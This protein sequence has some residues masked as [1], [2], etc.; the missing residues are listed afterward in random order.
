MAFD[1]G[2]TNSKNLQCPVN[3][4]PQEIR[5]GFYEVVIMTLAEA[6][7]V[8]DGKMNVFVRR[9]GPDGTWLSLLQVCRSIFNELSL[10]LNLRTTFQC[11]DIHQ[12]SKLL[13]Q[14]SGHLKYSLQLAAF[15]N[16]TPWLQEL[17]NYV[18]D[19]KHVRR[20]EIQ[21]SAPGSHSSKEAILNTECPGLAGISDQDFTTLC[22]REVL[23]VH[24]FIQLLGERGEV[25][26]H[27]TTRSVTLFRKEF[28]VL[29]HHTINA[30]QQQFDSKKTETLEGWLAFSGS[31]FG[32]A[33][34]AMSN[35]ELAIDS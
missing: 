19:F 18:D 8:E 26:H 22:N 12:F 20:I 28:H 14:T 5:Y 25:Y 27:K 21:F 7:A 32:R 17:R 16:P 35:T 6:A 11:Q 33:H 2:T 10:L 13:R 1:Y 34:L 9:Q 15:S 31:D 3:D 24:N 4:L 29:V 23:Q 30:R